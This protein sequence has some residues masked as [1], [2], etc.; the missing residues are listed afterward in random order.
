[1]D[2]NALKPYRIDLNNNNYIPIQSCK[3][4]DTLSMSFEMWNNGTLADI[5][6]WSCI[7]NASKGNN[8][9]WQIKN[10]VVTSD[11]STVTISFNS[12]LTQLAGTLLLEL[13]FYKGNLQKT[14][15]DIEIEV[16]K[17][18]IS[19]AN[20]NVPEPII[21]Q[22]EDLKDNVIKANDANVRLENT[23]STGNMLN[24]NLNNN[25]TTGTTLK[26]GLDTSITEGKEVIEDLKKTNSQYTEHINNWN[27]HLT[28]DEKKKVLTVI[29][30]WDAILEIL[31]K[32]SGTSYLIDENGD[33]FVD[34]NGDKMLI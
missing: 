24:S 4:N 5:S 28:E 13:L 23:I 11:N 19:D 8:K 33:Y 15:F 7:I 29:N 26:T 17:S 27:I 21:T 14:S 25:I 9:T 10:A 16:K 31:D 3:Q 12:T 32:L 22:L 34:E 18:I 20:G 1:M 6:G 2:I 30:N